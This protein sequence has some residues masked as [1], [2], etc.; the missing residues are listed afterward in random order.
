MRQSNSAEVQKSAPNSFVFVAACVLF[1]VFFQTDHNIYFTLNVLDGRLDGRAIS[2]IAEGSILNRIFLLFLLAF[3]LIIFLR[4]S[5]VK[6]IHDSLNRILF[7]SFLLWIWL[8]IFW[9]DDSALVVRR[10]VV[11]TI[12]YFAAF[13]MSVRISLLQLPFIIMVVTGSFLIIGF[14]TERILGTWWLGSEGYRFAGTCH[15][16]GQGINCAMLFLSA[17]TVTR[18]E[19]PVVW[20]FS[21]GLMA[22]GFIFLLLTRSRGPFIGLI[23]ALIVLQIFKRKTS[24]A[25]VILFVVAAM[26]CIAFLIFGDIFFQTLEMGVL[27]GRQDEQLL[28]LNG[29]RELWAEC[30]EYAKRRPM[31]GYGFGGFWNEERARAISDS[32]GWLIESSHSI[33]LE[34][35][36]DIGLIGLMIFGAI[37][38][39]GMARS[40][41]A[42]YD[43]REEG[44]ALTLCLLTLW[45]VDGLLSTLV[46]G[47]GFVTF[48]L[49]VVLFGTA[50]RRVFGGGRRRG[51]ISGQVKD[52]VRA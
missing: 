5:R 27:L 34:T 41:R 2:G 4:R 51:V 30:V 13:A 52:G 14:F 22:V 25:V 26:F 1:L 39:R 19:G 47:R 36:L 18:K 29:R 45:M 7:V 17:A 32:F 37:L 24:K 48:L 31:S 6:I 38:F 49:F 50:Q 10:I 35:V 8:S 15:P 11:F 43:R 21:R 3:S 20:I 42:L 9:A 44:T 12:I 28:E 23:V 33:Y 46:T 16:E 40:G